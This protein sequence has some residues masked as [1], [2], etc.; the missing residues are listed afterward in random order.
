MFLFILSWNFTSH[1]HGN[2]NQVLILMFFLCDCIIGVHDT[3]IT[4]RMDLMIKWS[5]H[6]Q[7][8]MGSVSYTLIILYGTNVDLKSVTMQ[9]K[10]FWCCY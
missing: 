8:H 4:F 7:L 6:P 10:Y 1:L 9:E 2:Y 3:K 5:L